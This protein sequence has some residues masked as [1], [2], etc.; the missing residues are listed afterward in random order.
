MGDGKEACLWSLTSTRLLSAYLFLWIWLK[1]G[2]VE[3]VRVSRK[4]KGWECLEISTLW[5]NED[6][7]PSEADGDLGRI[8]IGPHLDVSTLLQL[9]CFLMCETGTVVRAEILSVG[10]KVCPSGWTLR[11]RSWKWGSIDSSFN[12]I[13]ELTPCFYPF[14]VLIISKMWSWFP[15]FFSSSIFSVICFSC[16]TFLSQSHNRSLNA[17]CMSITMLCGLEGYLQNHRENNYV[18]R[19][20]IWKVETQ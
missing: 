9:A 5:D 18:K 11:S 7:Q 13:T 4:A 6:R 16:H 8:Q 2:E 20:L 19:Q 15:A 3:K 17:R 1:K 14:P 10:G 12:L